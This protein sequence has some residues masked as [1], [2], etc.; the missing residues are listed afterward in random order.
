MADSDTKNKEDELAGT[1]QPFVA[2]LAELR[3]RL[4]YC[5]YGVAAAAAFLVAGGSWAAV[6]LTSNDTPSGP[7]TVD[8][9]TTITGPDGSITTSTY[10]ATKSVVTQ[11]NPNGQVETSTVTNPVTTTDAPVTTTT[12]DP[13]TIRPIAMASPP[14]DIRLADSPS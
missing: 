1:E 9:T 4:L 13:S 3:D 5:A 8:V 6:G 12:T 7:V 14:S 2:H 11:T 10:K